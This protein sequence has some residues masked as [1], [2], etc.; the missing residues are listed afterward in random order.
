MIALLDDL[1]PTG[2]NAKAIFDKSFNLNGEVPEFLYRY[3]S[4]SPIWLETND[5]IYRIIW[6]EQS[7]DVYIPTIA[8][9]ETHYGEGIYLQITDELIK[10][11]NAINAYWPYDYWYGTYDSSK[12]EALTME[13]L[14]AA[15]SPINI[16]VKS[17]VFDKGEKI[18][19]LSGRLILEITA[20]TDQELDVGIK[21]QQSTDFFGTGDSEKVML[22]ANVPQTVELSF[23]MGG[24][25]QYYI[26]LLENNTYI[27]I[28]FW[29]LRALYSE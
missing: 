1:Q 27:R 2:F 26:T 15:D 14:Y 11:I 20:Q 22:Q 16:I 8:L 3:Y 28:V 21:C 29:N 13:H 5:K 19:D 12:S 9:V 23:S 17:I 24:I 10:M 4:Q 18:Y 25:D 6:E 7:K